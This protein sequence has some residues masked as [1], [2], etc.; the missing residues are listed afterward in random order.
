M[1]TKTKNQTEQRS[2][3]RTSSKQMTN[4]ELKAAAAI[5]EQEFADDLFREMTPESR[6]RWARVKKKMGRPKIGKGVKVVSVSLEQGLLAKTDHL[7]KRLGVSRASLIS[8]GLA[9]LVEEG[10]L[11]TGNRPQ[12]LSKGARRDAS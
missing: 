11:S 7:A 6:K 8:R 12:R 1:N 3:Q 5:Y 9:R 2:T 10:A 4:A